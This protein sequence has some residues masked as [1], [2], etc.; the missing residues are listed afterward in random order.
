MT[1][2]LLLSSLQ[3][4]DIFSTIKSLG[5][6]INQL[7]LICRSYPGIK[8]LEYLTFGGREYQL[9]GFLCHS[10]IS[11]YSGHYAVVVRCARSGDYYLANNDN[12]IEL[13]SKQ[14]AVDCALQA[15]IL[16]YEQCSQ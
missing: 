3:L 16:L 8:A 1:V 12:S 10:S 11:C 2:N 9:R 13:I 4:N 6:L 14:D 5:P 15:Y 7:H